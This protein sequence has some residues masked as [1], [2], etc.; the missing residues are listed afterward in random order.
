MADC[1]LPYLKDRP[2]ALNRHPNGIGEPGFFQ[3]N[4]VE[5]PPEWVKTVKIPSESRGKEV[6]TLL[7][8][9]RDTLIYEANLACI[10][11]NVWNSSAGRLGSPDYVVLDFD[12]QGTPFSGVVEVVLAAKDLLDEWRVPAFCK[13]SG[14]KGM[15]VFIPLEPRFTHEQA[16][17]LAHLVHLYVRRQLPDLTSLERDP[18]ARQGKV[19]LDYLQNRL[20]ATMAAPYSLRPR[21][22]APVSTPLEWKE[23]KPGLDPLEFNIRTA[24]A[25]AAKK[26]D[27]WKDLFRKRTDLNAV[28]ARFE[29]WRKK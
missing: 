13:T 12:P 18:S 20:G 25:R 6:N 26:G 14:G 23:V 5:P 2:Q 3:K 9:N 21:E 17:E 1:I 11:I 27:L 8:Q 24:P 29:K 16:R 22:G 15:H 10:E 28:L 19:Y 4:I 7:C